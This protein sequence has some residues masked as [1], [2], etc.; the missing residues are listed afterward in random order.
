MHR[1]RLPVTGVR[2]AL[3]T[4][5]AGALAAGALAGP[6]MASTGDGSSDIT[7]RKAG[8]KPSESITVRK[9]GG[10]SADAGQPDGYIIGVL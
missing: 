3:V 5:I 7:C 8:D 2:R 1:H 9:A 10:G 4:A 6:A